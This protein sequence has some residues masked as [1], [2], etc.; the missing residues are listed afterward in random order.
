M[1]LIIWLSA[2]KTMKTTLLSTITCDA[3]L[4]MRGMGIGL[5]VGS[6]VSRKK[7]AHF[8][9][10][11]RCTLLMSLIA[12]CGCMVRAR[13]LRTCL[14]FEVTN[15][16]VGLNAVDMV[17]D[18]LSLKSSSKMDLH[19]ISMLVHLTTIHVYQA[20]AVRVDRTAFISRISFTAKS[21]SHTSAGAEPLRRS[22]RR[23]RL[24]ALFTRSFSICSSHRREVCI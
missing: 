1:K 18:L 12:K 15:S 5:F 21:N 9:F 24:L 16:V 17:E 2:I 6:G 4:A 8:G 20:V 3:S 11:T 23:K 22:S 10:A 7:M 14:N 13:M 19:Y